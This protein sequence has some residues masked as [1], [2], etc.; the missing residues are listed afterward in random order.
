MV[1]RP[2]NILPK[3]SSNCLKSTLSLFALCIFS[4][5]AIAQDNTPSL[6][7]ASPSKL[8]LSAAAQLAKMVEALEKKSYQGTLTYEFGGPLETLLFK[9]IISK[10]ETHEHIKHLSGKSR[11]FLRKTPKMTCRNAAS[12]LLFNA[13][14]AEVNGPHEALAHLSR[15]YSFRRLGQNRI[16][17]RL[18]DIIQIR[19]RKADRYGMTLGVDRDSSL[20]LM[21]TVNDLRGKVLERFQFVEL[22]L[23]PSGG[24]PNKERAS[25]RLII[26]DRPCDT[27]IIEQGWVARWLPEGYALASI[28][29]ENGKTYLNFTD[30]LSSLSIFVVPAHQMS[31]AVGVVQRGATVAAMMLIAK[32]GQSFKVSVL[33]EIPPTVARKIASSIAYIP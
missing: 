33:G 16:A 12:R 13:E 32:G 27:P 8:G 3:F 2:L 14:S 5:N 23:A 1:K 22:N 30:G 28:S 15:Y 31:G 19:P 26:K 24:L 7:Q 21:M 11:D 4:L 18:A 25:Q 9:K 20:P 6:N 10:S 17:D 29:Q